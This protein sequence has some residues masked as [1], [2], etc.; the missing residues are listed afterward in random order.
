MWRFWFF[1]DEGK[2]HLLILQNVGIFS[3]A[4]RTS[5]FDSPVA[6]P[7]PQTCYWFPFFF[8]MSFSPNSC[9]GG[10]LRVFGGILNF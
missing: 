5:V 6:L 8:W 9:F 10:Y 1:N 2:T 7:L 3:F 4:F